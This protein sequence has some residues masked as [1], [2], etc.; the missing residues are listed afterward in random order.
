MFLDLGEVAFCRVFIICHRSTLPFHH[1]PRVS[2]VLMWSLSCICRLSLPSFRI[3]AFLLLISTPCQLRLVQRLL[4]A[5]WWEELVSSHWWVELLPGSPM[6]R[7]VSRGMCKGVFAFQKS[8]SAYLLIEDVVFL[9]FWLFGMRNPSTGIQMLLRSPS[10]GTYNSSKI[11]PPVRV[12]DE[13]SPIA[14][15]HFGP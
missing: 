7:A 11:Q 6:R 8:Y 1:H 10:L 15:P 12:P 13:F 3:I 5:F 14:S 2:L 4:Q 9:S